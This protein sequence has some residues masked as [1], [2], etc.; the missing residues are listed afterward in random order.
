MDRQDLPRQRQAGV[1]AG[2]IQNTGRG[3]SYASDAEDVQNR[4]RRPAPPEGREWH[5]QPSHHFSGEPADSVFSTPTLVYNNVPQEI[6]PISIIRRPTIVRSGRSSVINRGITTSSW[7]V[8]QRNRT[9]K[10][11]VSP[12]HPSCAAARHS[13]PGHPNAKVARIAQGERQAGAAGRTGASH[14]AG[15]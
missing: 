3:Q 11:P 10:R 5:V 1:E 14:G 12:D 15:V 8:T 6:I 13:N 4:C 2:T 7:P 9:G